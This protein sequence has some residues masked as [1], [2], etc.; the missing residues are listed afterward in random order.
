M[1]VKLRNLRNL[2]YLPFV[3]QDEAIGEL[4]LGI[5]KRFRKFTNHEVALAQTVANQLA[6]AIQNARLHSKI[7]NYKNKLEKL[8]LEPTYELSA[9]MRILNQLVINFSRKTNLF[10]NKSQNLRMLLTT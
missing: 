10:Q 6:I 7:L 5:C 3:Q 4:I 1:V 8:I 9:A 2:L